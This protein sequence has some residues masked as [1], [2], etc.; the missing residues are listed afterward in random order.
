MSAI[1][2]SQVVAFSRTH[3]VHLNPR[4]E[5]TENACPQFSGGRFCQVVARTGSTVYFF[6]NDEAEPAAGLRRTSG[7]GLHAPR[8][9]A[10][11]IYT[12]YPKKAR[13]VSG[14]RVKTSC[15]I[16][17]LLEDEELCC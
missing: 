4:I 6:K 2:I 14:I 1:R 8:A 5:G 12:R 3:S 11:R 13:L 7:H 9:V 16:K 10:K 17:R 15:S